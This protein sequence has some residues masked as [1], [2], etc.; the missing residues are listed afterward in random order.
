[1]PGERARLRRGEAA[2]ERFS[3]TGNAGAGDKAVR[4]V[5]SP[6]RSQRAETVHTL[7]QDA[8][9]EQNGLLAREETEK[10]FTGTGFKGSLRR[11]L[12]AWSC[13][14]ILLP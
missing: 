9:A 8:V 12:A 3:F 1:M 10:D 2:R 14:D 11:V 7:V 13:R 6:Q 5:V 4:S